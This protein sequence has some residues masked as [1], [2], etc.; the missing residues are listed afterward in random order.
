[1]SLKCV[2]KT[3]NAPAADDRNSLSIQVLDLRLQIIRSEGVGLHYMSFF[4]S[5]LG[6]PEAIVR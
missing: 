4:P 1:M 3:C 5:L 2:E 6:D